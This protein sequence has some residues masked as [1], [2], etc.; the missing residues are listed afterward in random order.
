MTIKTLASQ[1]VDVAVDVTET[2]GGNV[3]ETIS[4]DQTQA[5]TGNLDIDAAQIDLN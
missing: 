3:S 4:G 5:I 2:V 1:I